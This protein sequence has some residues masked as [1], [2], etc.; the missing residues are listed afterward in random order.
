MCYGFS[1]ERENI[2]YYYSLDDK[3]RT[4]IML[5]LPTQARHQFL[6]IQIIYKELYFSRE[7]LNR[8]ALHQSK[9][10]MQHITSHPRYF[11]FYCW[12][13]RTRTD[14]NLLRPMQAGHQFPHYPIFTFLTLKLFLQILIISF[15]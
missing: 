13:D 6:H 8:T 5:L 3:T 2:R 11:Y 1:R 14:I 4:C 15:H 9:W 10:R 7:C 12:V